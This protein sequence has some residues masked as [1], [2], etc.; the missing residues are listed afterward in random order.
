[1]FAH[2]ASPHLRGKAVIIITHGLVAGERLRNAW[3]FCVFSLARFFQILAAQ[4]WCGAAGN[5]GDD[6]DRALEIAPMRP[7]QIRSLDESV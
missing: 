7:A 5:S 3:F 2:V 4:S 1:M 6:I